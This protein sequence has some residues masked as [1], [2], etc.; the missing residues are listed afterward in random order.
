MPTLNIHIPPGAT[1]YHHPEAKMVSV[2]GMTLT[3][4]E[5]VHTKIGEYIER[6]HELARG[7][8]TQLGKNT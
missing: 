1:G 5:E 2:S 4:I 7:R 8:A 3:Q 6:Q